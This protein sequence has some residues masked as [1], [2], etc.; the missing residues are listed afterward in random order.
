MNK[1]AYI[2]SGALVVLLII[3]GF[4]AFGGPKKAMA[5]SAGELT[6]AAPTTIV[7]IGVTEGSISGKEG[8]ME[9]AAAAVKLTT[10]GF[11][12]A[13]VTVKLG[14]TVEWANESSKEMWVASAPHPSHTDYPEF[15]QLKGV[16]GGGS[17]SFTFTKP[18]TWKYHNHLNPGNFGSVEVK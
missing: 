10:T 18:G 7:N 4:V 14:D 2:I 3:A 5:P 13:K 9:K 6:P 15:D 11:I 12:P 17:Y 1:N 8:K 16:P